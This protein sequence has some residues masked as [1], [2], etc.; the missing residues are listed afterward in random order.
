LLPPFVLISR[1]DFWQF[2]QSRHV[3]LTE[4]CPEQKDE[5]T[6]KKHRPTQSQK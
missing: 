3:E 6:E 2:S 4:Y 1:I 5:R